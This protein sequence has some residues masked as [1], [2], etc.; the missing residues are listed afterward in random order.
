M[1]VKE[2][3]TIINSAF[4]TLVEKDKKEIISSAKLLGSRGGKKTSKILLKR[5][6]YFKKLAEKRWNKKK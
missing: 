1:K 4:H 6:D 3:E 5:K 2:F